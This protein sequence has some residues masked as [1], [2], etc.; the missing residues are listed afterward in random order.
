MVLAILVGLTGICCFASAHQVFEFFGAK[1]AALYIT[2]LYFYIQPL[3]GLTYT[4]LL[5]LTFGS[6]DFILLI[7]SAKT[8]N[9]TNFVIGISCLLLPDL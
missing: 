2:L 8:I 9:F 4:E 5:G 7:R 3:I 6:L 1:A